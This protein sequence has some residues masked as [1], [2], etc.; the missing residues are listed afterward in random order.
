MDRS[1]SRPA[2]VGGKM[3]TT[4]ETLAELKEFQ[5][6]ID[7]GK[8]NELTL[9][10]SLYA[11]LEEIAILDKELKERREDEEFLRG[12]YRLTSS[13]DGAIFFLKV[14]KDYR[15]EVEAPTIHAAIEQVRRK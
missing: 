15:I 9:Y 1:E 12:P 10:K 13:K 8:N 3:M 4:I 6:R 5:K 11:A 7:I 2:L 14:G